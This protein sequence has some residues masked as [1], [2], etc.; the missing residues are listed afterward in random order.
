LS[1][2]LRKVLIWLIGITI[3]FILL[4]LFAQPAPTHP[5]FISMPINP[6][7]IAHRG[8]AGLWPENTLVGFHAALELGVDLLEM[9]IHSSADNV[10]VVIHDDAVDRTTDGIGQVNELSLSELKEFDAGFH[11]SSDQG[12]SYPFRGQGIEIPTLEEVFTEFPDHHMNIEIKQVDPPI[13][14]QFCYLIREHAMQEQVL[15]AAFDPGTL[16]AFRQACPEVATSTTSTE[17]RILYFL[18]QAG[19]GVLYRPPAQA[20]QVPEYSGKYHVLNEKFIKVVI[21]KNFQ[22]HAYTINDEIDMSRLLELGLD[23]LI[24]DY[25]DSMISLLNR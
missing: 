16:S 3:G 17:V 22:V 24:T 15:V 4:L 2:K 8:G 1:T 18:S 20:V 10:L 21:Q 13:F 6:L 5:F 9:D 7:V 19:L 14:E 25:P 11:W 23:G 12:L